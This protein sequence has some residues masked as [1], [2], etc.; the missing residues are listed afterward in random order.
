MLSTYRPIIITRSTTSGVTSSEVMVG[1]GGL[2]DGSPSAG[3]R[4]GSPVGVWGEA[5]RCQIYTESLQLST[6]FLRR[7]VATCRV[8]PP[9]PPA[10]CRSPKKT[11]DLRESHDPT[12]WGRAAG[13][14]RAQPYIIYPPVPTQL[15]LY[16]TTTIRPGTSSLQVF[17]EDPT[18]QYF[19]IFAESSWHKGKLNYILS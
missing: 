8:R 17:Y 5:F 4:S 15:I 12:R 6:A 2:V 18:K 10:H 7:F 1:T 9:S 11:S 16:D 19:H 3:S 13:W 14:A